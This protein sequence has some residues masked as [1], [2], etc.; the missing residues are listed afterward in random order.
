MDVRVGGID[1]KARSFSPSPF[2]AYASFLVVSPVSLKSPPAR[3]LSAFARPLLLLR[4]L[5][6]LPF[7]LPA[8]LP[9]TYTITDININSANNSDFLDV[10]H[11]DRLLLSLFRLGVLMLESHWTQNKKQRIGSG[12]HGD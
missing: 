12:D 9:T 2:D 4:R 1:C 8:P 3:R 11:D 7:A 6:G 5:C 10:V